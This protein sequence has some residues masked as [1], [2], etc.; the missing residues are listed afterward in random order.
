MAVIS[1][2]RGWIIGLG[3]II[4]IQLLFLLNMGK[5]EVPW[6]AV[7]LTL[8][9]IIGLSNPKI[10]EQ[11]TFSKERLLTLES[12]A[13]GD[14]SAE[15]TLQ[16]L[17]IR[18]PIV[19]KMWRQRPL[20]GWGFS[21]VSW[22]YGDGHVGNQN[23]LMVSGVAG[24]ILLAGFLLYFM[25]KMAE[26]Y[27]RKRRFRKANPA[28]MLFPVFLLGWFIIHS[29]SG[30]QFAFSGLP[31][32]VIPQALFFSFGALIFAQSKAIHNG[33]RIP[34]SPAAEL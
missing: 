24:F 2:T 33:K 11:V 7:F 29:T 32:H 23:I 26:A 5:R 10:R 22:E 31:L 34:E 17:D 25:F 20:F 4:I 8:L 30:Q 14:R 27:M 1:A 12:L 28:L 18:S 13:E 15:K 19:M 3:T 6:L 21:D 9:F 16:R